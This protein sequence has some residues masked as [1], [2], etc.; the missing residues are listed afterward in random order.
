M[1]RTAFTRL[2]VVIGVLAVAV[3]ARAGQ[4]PSPALVVVSSLEVPGTSLELPG[5]VVMIVDPAVGKVV[6]QVPVGTT[7]YGVT[8]SPDG[9]LAFVG[10][11]NRGEGRP[12]A[13]SISVI[14][15]AARK[16]VRRVDVGKGVRLHALQ[17]AGDRVYFTASGNKSV[18]WYDPTSNRVE[19]FTLGQ[20][21]PH[22]LAVSKDHNTVYASNPTSNNVS[23]IANVRGGAVITHI[24]VGRT[25]EGIDIAPDGREVWTANEEGGGVSIITIGSRA[26][27][28]IDL[29][30]K[31]ANRLR[32]TPD[33]RLVL[34]LD[35]EAGELI[36]VDARARKVIKRVSLVGPGEIMDVGDFVVVP[37]GSRVYVTVGKEE[38]DR[39]YIGE[40]DLKTL[41]ITRRIETVIR[42]NAV[43][44]VQRN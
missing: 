23:V 17:V 44:W 33:G 38:G 6:G 18:G 8:V 43:A 36:V 25:P 9:R 15:L 16:E 26:V 28:T 3:V 21:G 11:P 2:A 30:T 22:M 24:P 5:G 13:D 19:Y 31:H 1:N 39:H 27:Q 4:T 7:P 34:L 35:R 20:G 40:V 14:D 12:E 42:P 37:D 32:F 29:Q 10:N 41:A